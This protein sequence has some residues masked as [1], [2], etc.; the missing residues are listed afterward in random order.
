M[1]IY[2]FPATTTDES[3]INF[4]QSHKGWIFT[5]TSEDHAVAVTSSCLGPNNTAWMPERNASF[6]LSIF[7]ISNCQA[8]NNI[9]DHTDKKRWILA[10]LLK[11]FPDNAQLLSIT[12]F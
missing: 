5:A 7:Y 10:R 8:I 3:F 9:P 11:A 2:Q 1:K 4:C 6:G 12:T